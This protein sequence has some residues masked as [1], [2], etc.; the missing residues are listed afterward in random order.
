[1]IKP[2]T[3]LPDPPHAVFSLINSPAS[4]EGSTHLFPMLSGSSKHIALFFIA[5][6]SLHEPHP[7]FQQFASICSS[8]SASLRPVILARAVRIGGLCKPSWSSGD[9]ICF[10]GTRSA[11]TEKTYGL[12]GKNEMGI[13]IIRPDGYV[14]YSTPISANGKNLDTIDKWLATTLVKTKM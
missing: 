13:I 2:G 9:D 5:D 3:M 4:F 12:N 11:S 8:Y 1:M 7:L 6:H 10:L 14:A